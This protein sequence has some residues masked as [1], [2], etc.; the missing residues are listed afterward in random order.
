[1]R[2]TINLT[3]DALVTHGND[4]VFTVMDGEAVLMSVENGKY[5]KL[6]DIGTRIWSL[7]ETPAAIDSLCEQLSG[8]FQVERGDCERDVLLLLDRLLKDQ[9]I[10]VAPAG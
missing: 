2:E 1:M 3:L 4:Q 10:R 6:D 8:E 7:I 5:Y 9:L